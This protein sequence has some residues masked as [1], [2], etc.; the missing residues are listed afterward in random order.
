ME[1]ITKKDVIAAGWIWGNYRKPF[2]FYSKPGKGYE[3]VMY[4]EGKTRRQYRKPKEWFIWAS[5]LIT[6]TRAD[7]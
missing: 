3:I 6:L 4:K 5:P 7:L 2:M 1:H